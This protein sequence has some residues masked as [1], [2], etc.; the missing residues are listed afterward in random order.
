MRN[1]I[2]AATIGW[3]ALGAVT[4]A[5]TAM[6]DDGVVAPRPIEQ[7]APAPAT[8][9]FGMPIEGWVKV[10]YSVL[11]N[12]TTDDVR[13]VD[14]MPP[15][16]PAGDAVHAVER[17][18]FEPATSGGEP[19]DWHN[20]VSVVVFHNDAAPN[21][22]TPFFV[23]NYLEVQ[24]LL[25]EQDY[26]KALAREDRMVQQSI[27][28][29]NE[30][31]LAQTLAA[32]IHWGLDDPYSAWEAIERAAIPEVDQLSDK[33]L[34]TA[35]Y[36]R[37]VVALNLG[38]V[39][40]AVDSYQRLSAIGSSHVDAQVTQQAATIEERLGDG[41][42]V[43][44]IKGRAGHDPWAYAPTRRTFAFADVDG[45]IDD[46]QV[47][48]NRR[49]ATLE[50]QPDVEWTLPESWGE[51]TIFVDAKRGTTFTLYEFP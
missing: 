4:A 13:A 38:Y 24:K 43:I 37:Y 42:S 16:I 19:I 28:R 50:Y 44:Q 9:P 48:C 29:L 5:G 33:D 20:N 2:A 1:R 34:E 7:P 36:Y 6:A 25:K 32:A 51:C 22:P 12:G 47:E 3:V 18:T 14:Q 41:K 31:G 17:W 40:E 26:K 23:T 35:L 49:K 46:I 10:R 21:E 39:E 15:Q 27:T 45:G 30:I 8:G 11:A